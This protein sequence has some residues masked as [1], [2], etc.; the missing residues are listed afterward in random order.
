MTTV[1]LT[2]LLAAHLPPGSGVDFLNVDC[3]G[4]DLEVLRGLDWSRWSPQVIA[5]EAYTDEARAA[6][7]DFLVGP[8]YTPVAQN[9]LT[10]IFVR[11]PSRVSDLRV[12][13]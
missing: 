5:I 7:T 2:D 8:G 4:E 11:S 12:Y 1:T 10:L 9:L 3:E 13:A 6:V